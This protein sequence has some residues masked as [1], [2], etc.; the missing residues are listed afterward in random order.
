MFCTLLIRFSLTLILILDNFRPFPHVDYQLFLRGMPHLCSWMKRLTA[1]DIKRNK[2]RAS[3]DSALPPDFYALS[4]EHPLPECSSS[5]TAGKSTS[6]GRSTDPS[7]R[8]QLTTLIEELANLEKRKAEIV[9]HLQSYGITLTQSNAPLAQSST[10]PAVQAAAPHP[11][12]ATTTAGGTDPIAALAASLLGQ[13]SQQRQGSD[14]LMRT[15]GG[16]GVQDLAKLLSNSNSQQHDGRGQQQAAAAAGPST[17]TSAVVGLPPGMNVSQ[18]LGS[19]ANNPALLAPTPVRPPVN[20]N[21]N[22][23]SFLLSSMNNSTPSSSH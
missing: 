12:A 22:L 18:L 7:G 9:Q 10:V 14:A 13:P 16:G 1:K 11:A 3:D 2:K 4:R 6:S 21:S 17:S 23:L 5:G 15:F 8:P 19:L 20:P